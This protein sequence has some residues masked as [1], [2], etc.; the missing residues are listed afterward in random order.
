VAVHPVGEDRGGKGKSRSE[1][2][3]IT[4]GTSRS[5]SSQRVRDRFPPLSHL[6]KALDFVFYPG[7]RSS[8]THRRFVPRRFRSG[9]VPQGTRTLPLTPQRLRNPSASL[10]ANAS[11]L[12]KSSPLQHFPLNQL[13]LFSTLP[14]TT[15]TSLPE[16]PTP[17]FL[18]GIPKGEAQH[19]I[20]LC[21]ISMEG[22]CGVM[23]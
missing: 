1:G 19:Q 14:T 16:R 5:R 3:C 6:R 22:R 23:Q 4:E 15:G 7:S 8:R 10:S 2:E 13:P 12:Q 20:R 18:A 21:L 17:A 9:L 11:V